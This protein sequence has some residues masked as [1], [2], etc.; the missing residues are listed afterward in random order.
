[1]SYRKIG[2]ILGKIMILEALL[3]LAPL[4]VSF[5]Y[6]ESLIYKLA[7]VIP[8]AVLAIAG[9]LLQLLKPRRNTLYQKE[10]F[11]LTALV[12][13]VMALF[14]AVPF[15]INGDIPNYVDACFE[16][17]SG[18]TT[19]GASIV[20]DITAMSHSTLFWRSFSHWIGGMGILVF[21][22]IF[23]PESND[24]SSMHLLRAES[25][26]P[27]VGK[28]VSKMKVTTRILYL[29]YLGMTVLEIIILM[30][31]KPIAGYESEQFF[32][33]L[34]ATFGC[35]GTGGFGFIPGSMEMFNP[36]SQYVMAT[37]LIMFGVNFSL[38]YLILVGKIRDV[39][40][41]EEFRSYFLMVVCAI[42]F[43]FLSLMARFESYPQ[44]YTTE[45]AFRHSYFQVASLMTTTG[46][47]TQ[48]YDVWPMLAKTVLV[49]LM[50][51]GAMAGSTAGGI[52]VSRIV[53]AMKGA[54]I[55][56]RK[57]INPRYVPKANFE[58]KTLEQKT[59]NDVFG[60][61]TLYLFLLLAAVFILSFDPANGQVVSIASDAGVNTVTHGF[62]S[63]FS[64]VLA[65]IS[66]IGPAFEAIGPYASYAD[67]SVVSKIALA[68]MMLIGRLEIF[69]VLILFSRRTWKRI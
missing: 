11:A 6:R 34:L 19:T 47:T 38:Y 24:G 17:M 64:A 20:T 43:V 22:L 25:P 51:T 7:F 57:L 36:F 61:I 14:G 45:E 68:L 39:L 66:N 59:I 63:N 33:S 3:M 4:A 50:F 56:I 40:R 35:A 5:F 15:V 60:F 54:F 2:K 30:L 10:G 69:P 23:I 41:S 32:F 65:C 18:F 8:S 21:V 1:M 52:K 49:L 27:Q 16:I 28:I 31:D 9:L 37:F 58:G 55:N 62:F 53:I 42:G 26:G 44:V 46:F 29:I 48:D 12:W 13:V 67:Y